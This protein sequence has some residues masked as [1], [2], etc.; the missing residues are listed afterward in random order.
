MKT[1]RWHKPSNEYAA[2]GD[3]M[4]QNHLVIRQTCT[5]AKIGHNQR[6]MKGFIFPVEL[7]GTV[8]DVPETLRDCF[9]A[10]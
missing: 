9:K 2:E 3:R 4:N 7:C 8:S 10:F 1:A 6:L 5:L